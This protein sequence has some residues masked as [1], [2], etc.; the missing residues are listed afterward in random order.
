[1]AF[2]HR[3]NPLDDIALRRALSCLIDPAALT[4]D[5]A[6]GKV[7][8]AFGWIP[9]ENSGWHTGIIEPPCSGLDADARLAAGMRTLQTAGYAWEQEPGTNQVGRGLTLPSGAE[10]PA[11]TLLAPSEDA[12]R[13][14]A[15]SLIAAAAQKLGIPLSAEIVPSDE[16]F[17]RVYGIRDY[18][19][20]LLGWQL[21]LYPDYLCRFF[22]ADN[23]YHYQN[24][25]LDEKCDEFLSTENLSQERELLF[26]IEI[27]L[28]DDLP[29]LP[30][31]SSKLTEAYRNL[32]LS[33]ETYWGG[34]AA[35]P[36]GAFDILTK[37]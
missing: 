6:E 12:S 18:D 33:Q 28:W 25:A 20:A 22:T 29:A 32:S 21:S 10:F 4:A 9:P 3:K 7:V 15:A 16:L 11:L 14:A 26:Q 1:L 24:A 23:P 2:N 35:S 30:L 31:F 5:L 8:P 17:F 19:M 34:I 27:L 37:P 13:A 36:Y